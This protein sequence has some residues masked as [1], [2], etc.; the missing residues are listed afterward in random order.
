MPEIFLSYRRDESGGHAGRLHE[1]LAGAFGPERIFMDL[2][3]EPGTDFRRHIEEAIDSATIVIALIGPRWLTMTNARDERRLDDPRDF[4]RLEIATALRLQKR[5]IPTLVGGARPPDAD[6]LPKDLARLADLNAFEI[7]DRRWTFDAG[8]L[9]AALGRTISA[10]HVP[11]PAPAAQEQPPRGARRSAHDA[12]QALAD[13]VGAVADAVRATYGPNG[14][15]VVIRTVAG[16]RRRT[17]DGTTIARE[18]LLDDVFEQEGVDLAVELAEEMERAVGGGATTAILLAESLVRGCLEEGERSGLSGRRL[19][20]G[21]SRA[22]NSAVAAL[23]SQA[24]AVAADQLERVG[25]LAAEDDEVGKILG[26]AFDAVGHDGVVTVEEGQRFG[27]DLQVT[28]GTRFPAGYVS[29]R[30]VTDEVRLEAVLDDPYILIA[31]LEISAIHTLLPVL[32]MII[33]SGRPL[34][35]VARDVVG[36]SLATLIVN[37]DRGTFTG[38][39]IRAPDSAELRDALLADLAVLTGSTVVLAQL[40]QVQLSQLGRARRAV[41]GKDA[42]TLI[43]VAGDPEAI[44]RRISELESAIR[45]TD[46]AADR[47]RLRARLAKLVGG[48]AVVQVGAATQAELQ[49]RQHRAE[50]AV[51]ATAAALDG[52]VVAGGGAALLHA[53]EGIESGRADDAT[54]AGRAIVAAALLAPLE[55]LAESAGS[56]PELIVSAL[57]AAPGETAFD[58]LHGMVVGLGLATAPL[59]PASVPR[60]A[61]LQA[62]AL[63]ERVLT[64]EGVLSPGGRPDP[65]PVELPVGDA[66]P[67]DLDAV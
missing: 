39:A 41:I 33:Q 20:R 52:G 53:A 5:V 63:A 27:V 4:V 48:V 37:K 8:Q 60:H 14:H 67:V 43:D 9:V 36:E 64:T 47:E 34:L 58:A 26:S 40:E 62:A 15:Y 55:H 23:D 24:Q 19:L 7:S 18:L 29:P 16:D 22:V 61:L 10:I 6:A 49:A 66:G 2:E 1:A 54:E 28:E 50:L 31:D 57:E 21:V 59:D 38:I 51:R 25:T 56:D 45:A 13:G 12:R 35:I 42:T 46:A 17:R 11:A 30:M 3:I 32:E 44:K 65:A